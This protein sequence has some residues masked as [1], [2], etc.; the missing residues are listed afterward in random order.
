MTIPANHDP[1]DQLLPASRMSR[2]TM[3][4]LWQS[5]LGLGKLAMLDGDPDQGKSLVALDLCARL[6]QGGL[7]PDGTPGIGVAN[8]LILQERTAP[9]TR[10]S[11]V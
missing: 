7:M 3:E 6:S 9:T 10:S 11:L 2:R 5:R 8:S 4:W 1:L